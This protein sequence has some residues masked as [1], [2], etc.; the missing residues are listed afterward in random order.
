MVDLSLDASH[1][2]LEAMFGS[3]LLMELIVS[4]TAHWKNSFIDGKA[5]LFSNGGVMTSRTP[6]I[7]NGIKFQLLT[8]NSIIGFNYVPLFVVPSFF[9]KRLLDG[10]LFC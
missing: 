7:M 9:L 4:K 1:K 2:S 5:E 8:R 10:P 6:K 3:R